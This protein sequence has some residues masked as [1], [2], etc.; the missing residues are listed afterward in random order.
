MT[1]YKF[2]LREHNFLL[3]SLVNYDHIAQL[4]AFE[5][6][7]MDMV[8]T[9]LP[10]AA[11]FFEDVV[12]PTNHA[13]DRQGSR[14]EQN[15]VIPAP[16]LD[17]I[18]TQMVD[19]GW[20]SLSGRPEYGGAGFPGVA[21]LPLMEMLQSSNLSFSLLPML[22]QGVIHSLDLYGNETQKA[23]Y[24]PKLVSG[25]WSGTMN[26]TE[27]QAGSDLS[28]IK[29]RALP[30]GDHY[31]ISGQKIFITWGDH[32]YAENVIQ[33]V[34]AKTPDAPQGTNGISMFIVP[35]YLANP[36]GSLGARNDVKAVGL[37]HKLGIHASPTCTMQYGDNGGAVGYLVGEENKGLKYMFA[38]MNAARLAVGVQGIAVSERAYQQ[39]VAYAQQRVQ[40]QVEGLNDTAT[41]V[42]HPDVRRML[43]LMKVLTEAG[44][45]LC[46]QAYALEDLG[47]HHP[48]EAVRQGCER[49]MALLTP[50]VKG[51]GTEIAQE[52]TGLG[53]QVHGGMGFME[54]TG[55]AQH[56]RDARILTIYEGTNGIQA[57]DFI[58]RKTLR[59]G[60]AGVADLL[61]RMGATVAELEQ[62]HELSQLQ[63]PLAAAIASCKQALD[64]V[65]ANPN[66]ASAAAFNYMMLFANTTCAWLLARSAIA[67]VQLLKS[68]GADNFYRNK[69]ASVDFYMA[70]VL[71]RNGAYLTALLNS[72]K[73]LTAVTAD[74]F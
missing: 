1:S 31:L 43:M 69:L 60:G 14:L 35:K 13:A 59:D 74:I 29:T 5:G 2:P 62:Q 37:E 45:A 19:A 15:I 28:R 3:N 65:L 44:R 10:E 36:D 17:G 22:T 41:I 71:P 61:A 33:L 56:Y 23:L 53:I 73:D 4:P 47:I 18:Y 32:E 9:I 63:A 67:A 68:E 54:E 16:A 25:Q 58:G 57:L 27:P 6:V 26:L 24:L 11:K 48:D 30:N 40:G 66:A 52:V 7:G 8:A 34:L 42:Q 46:Y 20:L 12:A 64:F 51:W 49:A 72:G 50:L 39:A 70:H 55:A 38:V 21:A